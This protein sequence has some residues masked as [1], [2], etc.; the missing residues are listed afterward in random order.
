[1]KIKSAYIAGPYSAPTR[2]LEDKNIQIAALVAGNYIRQGWAVF[3]P[4]THSCLIARDFGPDDWN[5]WL[6]LDLYWLSKCDIVVFLPGWKESKG[7]SIEHMVARGL[8]KEIVY[9]EEATNE[10]L[11]YAPAEEHICSGTIEKRCTC[12]D[13]FDAGR[14]E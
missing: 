4:H 3:C 7:A 13:P 1:M 14:C 6:I 10:R 5:T 9:L 2:E 12:K 8:S 11:S